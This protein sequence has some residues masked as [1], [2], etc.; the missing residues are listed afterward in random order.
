MKI[1]QEFL[2][3]QKSAGGSSSAD[4][5]C[6]Y[7][8]LGNGELVTFSLLEEDPLCYFT[9]WARSKQS[10]NDPKQNRPFRFPTRPTEDE[11]ETELGNDYIQDVMYEDRLKPVEM[12]R[13]RQPLKNFTWPV[14]NWD[15]KKVQ[16]LEC[17]HVSTREGMMTIGS[18]R[19][20]KKMLLDID[21]DISKT[22]S[23]ENRTTYQVNASPRDES[24]DAEEAEAAYKAVK[25][26][27]FDLNRLVVGGDPFSEA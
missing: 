9:V 5:Y 1:P 3:E 24:H 7:Y 17:N 2:E 13:P 20:W 18:H 12:Q 27:G 19:T 14:Y 15:A 21:I 10:P 23:A 16:V 26:N 25:K 4:D 22:V 11:I 6:Q 8:K